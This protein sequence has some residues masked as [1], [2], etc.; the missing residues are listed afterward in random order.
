MFWIHTLLWKNHV[1]EIYHGTT[2]AF[3]IYMMTIPCFRQTII[4]FWINIMAIPQLWRFAKILPWLF[5]YTVY[6]GN[7]VFGYVQ[8]YT[9]SFRMYTMETQCFIRFTILLPSFGYI[10]YYGNT[11][12]WRFTMEIYHGFIWW[13]Y[14][15]SDI[16]HGTITDFWINIIEIPCFW[17]FTIVFI[18]VQMEYY[19]NTIVLDMILW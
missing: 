7:T 3:L 4:Y 10:P 8:L 18:D 15:A 9:M 14:H 13:Q 1:L 17:R 11:M 5:R 19:V 12:F 6:Y 16:Y 2:M